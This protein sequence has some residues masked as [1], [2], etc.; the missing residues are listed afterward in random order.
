MFSQQETTQ[1]SLKEAVEFALQNNYMGKN[2][3]RDVEIAKLQKW[4]TT[5]TG[6]PQIKAAIKYNNWLKQQISLIPQN[7]LVDLQGSFQKL[8]LAPNKQ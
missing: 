6:L 7:F 4:Q 3:A 5:S 1:F 8:L 2:A